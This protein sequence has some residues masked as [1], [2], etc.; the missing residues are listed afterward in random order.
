M[1]LPI[2]LFLLTLLLNKSIEDEFTLKKNLTNR[3]LN[4]IYTNLNLIASLLEKNEISSLNLANCE[5]NLN[6][7][8][9]QQQ[10]NEQLFQIPVSYR[11][12]NNLQNHILT[13][14]K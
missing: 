13:Y 2:F 8:R 3:R 1:K 6:A 11:H 7:K 5:S 4:K 9:K 12:I 14:F 10:Q